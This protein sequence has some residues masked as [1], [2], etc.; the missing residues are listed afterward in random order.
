VLQLQD[1]EDY[2]MTG[3]YEE[4]IEGDGGNVMALVQE[5]TSVEGIFDTGSKDE[6]TMWAEE[7]T[8]LL[9]PIMPAISEQGLL[10]AFP[11]FFIERKLKN[12]EINIIC[13]FLLN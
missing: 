9:V 10:S 11:H 4:Q 6:D 8:T 3:N 7:S 2:N 1:D 5:F 13:S 12:F